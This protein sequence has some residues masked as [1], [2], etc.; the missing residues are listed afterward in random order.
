[1]NNF[2][3]RYFKLK[4]SGTSVRTEVLAGLTTFLTMAYIIAVNP[5]MVS[6]ATGEGTVGALVTATCLASA[7]ACILM[8]LYA[9]LP[10]A[11]APGMGLNAYFTY[12]VCLGMGVSWKVAF[13]AIFVEGIVFI[14]LSLTNVRE[15]VVK[16]IPLSLKMAVTVGIG[17]FIAFIGFSNAKIIESNPSTYVQ[18]GSFITAPV[19]IAVT[20]LLIIVVLSKKNIKGAILWG[21][22]I[23]TVLSWIYALINPGAANYYGIHLPLKVFE[24]ESLS[25]LL[26]QIDLS[27]LFDSEKVLNFIIIL[28]TFLFV[29]FFD[30]VGTLVGVASKANMLDEKGNVPRAGKALLT[31]AIG[32]TVGSLIGATTVTTYVESSTGVAEGGRTG[33]TAIVTGILFFLAMFF[34]PI[35]IAIPSCATAPALIYVGFLMMQEVTKIDFKDITQ[36][37]PAFI[38][39]AAMPLTYSIGDGLTL[40]V[41]S[42][43][44]INL[45]H[46][47]TVKDKRD[48]HQVSIVMIILAIIFVFKL[49]L[50]LFE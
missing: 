7:F 10:F 33:L 19:L 45:I 9:N 38:T 42:Y 46:N 30:T 17:L 15:A 36:G 12:S 2:L 25:P 47:M 28:F 13:G 31:D 29:D 50:P 8:G 26:F 18:L 44:F 24:Y 48:K 16:A 34:S 11:L 20:G 4:D 49:A 43:V 14:I 35:F 1:M 41:L 37:F 3:E 6:Q 39:I 5:G 27:Y 40:G 21:I 23:S 32:T 22:V